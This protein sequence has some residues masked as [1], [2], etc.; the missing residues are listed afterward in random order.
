[1][2]AQPDA[3][4]AGDEAAGSGWAG[5]DDTTGF[6]GA[7]TGDSWNNTAPVTAPVAETGGWNGTATE[8]VGNWGDQ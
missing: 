4:F 6:T 3:G 5:G 8:A 7:A 2:V 1:V